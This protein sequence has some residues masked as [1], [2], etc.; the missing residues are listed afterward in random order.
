MP[1]RRKNK[2]PPLDPG[3]T[4]GAVAVTV[5]WVMSVT[6]VLMCEAAAVAAHLAARFNPPAPRIQLFS[7]WM[8][9]TSAAVGAV[10]LA[11]LPAVYRLRRVLPPT[12]LAVFGACA[13]AAPIL[14]VVTRL[15]REVG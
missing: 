10:S 9:L 1:G 6:T 14:A 13:A 7:T 4:R 5:A 12:G 3:E 11:L 8:L 2:R 15:L